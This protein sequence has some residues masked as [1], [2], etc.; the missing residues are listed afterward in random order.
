MQSQRKL[1]ALLH[2]L[3]SQKHDHDPLEDP[4]EA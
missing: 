1:I 2:Q 4:R 3:R